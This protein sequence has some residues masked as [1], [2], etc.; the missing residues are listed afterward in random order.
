MP[1]P[2]QSRTGRTA[3][4]QRQLHTDTRQQGQDDDSQI[5]TRKAR[6]RRRRNRARRG[7][8]PLDRHQHRWQRHPRTGCR[9]EG[10]YRQQRQQWRYR[11]RRRRASGGAE[12]QSG[13]CRAVCR[14]CI[15]LTSCERV[16]YNAYVVTTLRHIHGP[17][18]RRR[19]V[20]RQAKAYRSRHRNRHRSHRFRIRCRRLV[21]ARGE[22]PGCVLWMPVFAEYRAGCAGL[23][24]QA[25]GR[26]ARH[27]GPYG[28]MGAVLPRCC[29]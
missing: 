8:M 9:A 7:R 19:D 23:E 18:Y 21:D 13:Q 16:A 24:R 25:K 27:A 11:C 26:Q 4:V 28:L 2:V 14:G 5:S 20:W 10:A 15:I 1:V 3:T 17:K 12:T 29:A 6:T 22:R